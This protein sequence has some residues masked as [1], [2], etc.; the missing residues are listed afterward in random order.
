MHNKNDAEDFIENIFAGL[1]TFYPGSK[2][3][4][5][6]N[7]EVQKTAVVWDSK[8]VIKTLPNGNDVEMFTLGALASALGRPIITLRAWMSAGYLPTSPYRLPSTLDK[9]GKEVQ[10]RRL[11]TRP[12]IE[13]TVGLFTKAGLLSAKRIEWSINRH[14]VNEIAEAW[15]KIR[16]TETETT[17]TKE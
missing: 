16:A 14:L 2:R 5:R 15:D 9:N 4:R 17:K 11:Y 6:E 3:K 7:T 13:V 12:M 8:P 10:G 1:D